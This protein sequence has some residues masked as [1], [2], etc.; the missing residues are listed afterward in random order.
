MH[1]QAFTGSISIV[2]LVWILSRN[3]RALRRAGNDTGI[4]VQLIIR[5]GIF[6]TYV[7]CGMM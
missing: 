5:V 7:F 3:W 4:D 6:V 2:H 1:V